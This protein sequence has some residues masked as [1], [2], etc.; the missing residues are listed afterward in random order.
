MIPIFALI[1]NKE[2]WN[3]MR[4]IVAVKDARMCTSVSIAAVLFSLFHSFSL[5]LV[6]E[7]GFGNS[8]KIK[9]EVKLHCRELGWDR[10]ICF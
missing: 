6:K 7:V 5:V 8:S 9:S 2:L 3:R 1:A 4:K 10:D